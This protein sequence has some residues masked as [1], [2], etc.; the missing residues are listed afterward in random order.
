[1]VVQS[2][3]YKLNKEDLK[4]IGK[5]ALIAFAGTA[6]TLASDLI[7]NIDWGQY[8]VIVVPIASVLVNA[9]LKWYANKGK[10]I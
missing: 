8:K 7:P 9:G 10:L 1:M 5:G 2:T 3:K 6:L 4:K